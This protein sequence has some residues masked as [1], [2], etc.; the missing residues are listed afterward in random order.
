MRRS[1]RRHMYSTRLDARVQREGCR[2]V[3]EPPRRYMEERDAKTPLPTSDD[4]LA[5]CGLIFCVRR[6]RCRHRRDEYCGGNHELRRARRPP[7]NHIAAGRKW[8]RAYDNTTRVK[9][10]PLGHAIHKH[11]SCG[12]LCKHGTKRGFAAAFARGTT[13]YKTTVNF[14]RFV[15]SSTA[16]RKSIGV[17]SCFRQTSHEKSFPMSESFVNGQKLLRPT[18][19]YIDYQSSLQH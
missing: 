8:Q 18:G 14:G 4:N 6:R 16:K 19:V 5:L 10:D 13:L 1:F 11:G 9:R 2:C 17:V 12:T 7:E 15:F 3:V